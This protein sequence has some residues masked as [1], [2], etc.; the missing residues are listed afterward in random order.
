MIVPTTGAEGFA[1]TV[2]VYMAVAAAHGKPNGL[3][4]VIVMITV[5]P[6]SPA[7][8]VYVNANGRVVEDAGLTEPEPF[9]VIV[10]LVAL[11]P[12]V[13]PLT[14]TGVVPQVLPLMLLN[15]IVGGLTHWH[16]I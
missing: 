11:P 15:V 13:F 4:V 14:V 16:D 9:S 5:L 6:A 8:G 10:T 3:L 7:E 2:S 1:F 12:K